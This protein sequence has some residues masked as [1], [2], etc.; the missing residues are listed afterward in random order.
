M[1]VIFLAV[2]KLKT[3]KV[4]AI[5][6]QLFCI[7]AIWEIKKFENLFIGWERT[8]MSCPS[9]EEQIVLSMLVLK[10]HRRIDA[11]ELSHRSSSRFW[12]DLFKDGSNLQL[13][14][15]TTNVLLLELKQHGQI[16]K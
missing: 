15:N 6:W 4:Y 8:S 11:K 2:L 9:S 3:T 5:V 10:F 13:H 14:I 1:P 7:H 12:K 16:E